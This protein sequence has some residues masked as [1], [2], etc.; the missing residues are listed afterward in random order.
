M[1]KV[2]VREGN[3]RLRWVISVI[4]AIVTYIGLSTSDGYMSVV[5]VFVVFPLLSGL[6]GVGVFFFI[7]CIY[8][9][10]EGFRKDR[11]P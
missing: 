1:L 5:E 2:K 7:T 10:D 4:G 11:Q 6:A 8:W 9:V 3:R